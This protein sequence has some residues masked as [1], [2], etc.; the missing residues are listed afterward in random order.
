LLEKN[1]ITEKVLR[2]SVGIEAADDLIGDLQAAFI[3]AEEK[4]HERKKY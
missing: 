3:K 1:G 4:L 2:L